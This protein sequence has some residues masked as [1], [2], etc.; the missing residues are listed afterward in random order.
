MNEY[1][2]SIGPLIDKSINESSIQ[3]TNKTTKEL[4]TIEG[5]AFGVEQVILDGKRFVNCTFDG[6]EL[7]YKG[8]DVFS[9][10][11]NDFTGHLRVR[12]ADYAET[13]LGVLNALHSAG[14]EFK[15]LISKTF[16]D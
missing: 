6:S 15:E 2:S 1:Q 12:F 5:K 8:H 9:L 7:V 16:V 3:S 11:K 10:E 13:T 14:P 4:E